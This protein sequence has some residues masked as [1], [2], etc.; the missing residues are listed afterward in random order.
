[1]RGDKKALAT[2]PVYNFTSYRI[3]GQ[4][5]NEETDSLRNTSMQ[6][7]FRGGG[8]IQATLT[9]SSKALANKKILF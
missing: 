5:E 7:V 6:Q 8:A 4:E 2:H 3:F 9:Q 1:M